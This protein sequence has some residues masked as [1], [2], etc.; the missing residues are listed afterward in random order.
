MFDV[1]YL[2]PLPGLYILMCLC[3][4]VNTVGYLLTAPAVAKTCRQSRV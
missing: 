1:E 4:T 2:S 3:P